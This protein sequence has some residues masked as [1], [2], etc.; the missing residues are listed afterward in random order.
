LYYFNREKQSPEVTQLIQ[1]L[2][3]WLVQ[4][5]RHEAGYSWNLYEGNLTYANAILPEAMLFARQAT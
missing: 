4:M 1:V 2:A 3:D 5:C